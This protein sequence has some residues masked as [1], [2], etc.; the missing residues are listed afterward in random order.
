MSKVAVSDQERG[1]KVSKNEG[2]KRVLT[3]GK[4]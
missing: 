1:N 3:Q 4:Y 2:Y